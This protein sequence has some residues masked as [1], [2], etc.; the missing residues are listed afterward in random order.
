MA[1][2][3][4]RTLGAPTAACSS[5]FTS[6][7]PLPAGSLT[8]GFH[9]VCGM[10]NSAQAARCQHLLHA[11]LVCGQPPRLVLWECHLDGHVQAVAATDSAAERCQQ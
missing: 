6:R 8:A 3:S 9:T 5:A 11:D 2:S 1:R 10:F 4:S 7:W